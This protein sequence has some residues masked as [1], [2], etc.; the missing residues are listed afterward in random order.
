[1]E[2]GS[3][4]QGKEKDTLTVRD[5]WEVTLVPDRDVNRVEREDV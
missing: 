5:R 2:S 3:Q 4:R 1:M